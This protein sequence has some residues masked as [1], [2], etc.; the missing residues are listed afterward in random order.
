MDSLRENVE[1]R[2]LTLLISIAV[3]ESLTKSSQ[4]TKAKCNHAYSINLASLFD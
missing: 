4:L 1:E 3:L 2:T